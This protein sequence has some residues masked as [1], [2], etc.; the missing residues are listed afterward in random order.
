[1]LVDELLGLGPL[2]ELLADPD[3]PAQPLELGLRAGRHA[4]LGYFERM[5]ALGVAHML[6]NLQGP[7]PIVDQI[8]ELGREIV[9]R[10]AT[11][12]VR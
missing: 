6:V 12:A 9:P 2:E 10:L 1:M 8:E 3:V 5:A 7:R 11:L 4:L